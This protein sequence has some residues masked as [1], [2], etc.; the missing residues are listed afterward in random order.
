V[1]I[2]APIGRDGDIA[3]GILRESGLQA[4]AHANIPGLCA[5]IGKGAG[6]AVIAD[7]ALKTADLRPLTSFLAEQPAWSDFPIVV[8][9]KSGGG[10]ERNPAAARLAALLGNVTFLERP[11]HPTTMV[12]VVH[13][14]IR[15][16]KRQYEARASLVE[17][18]ESSDRLRLALT[19]G[20][21]GSWLYDIGQN[22]LQASHTCKTHFGQA[23][24]EPF[25][26]DDL[27][28]SI[29]PEDRGEMESAVKRSIETGS[30]H[31]IEVR[32]VWPAGGIH[33]IEMQG[34]ARQ[35]ADGA[36]VQLVGVSADITERK[37]AD[38]ERERLLHDLARER[39]ALARLTETLEQRVADE[40]IER[41]KVED[42]LR[43]GQKMEAIGQLTGGVAHDFNNLLMAVMG[44]LDLLQ[45]RIGDDP[46]SQRL[47]EGALQG[48]KRG[49]SLTQRMLAFARQQDLRTGSVD[50]K[51]LIHGMQDLLTRTLGPQFILALTL[52]EGLPSAEV[53][54]NQIELAVLNLVI[55]ARDAM[56]AGGTITVSCEYPDEV[57]ASLPE[58]NYVRIQ[59]TD[60]G[61]GMSS[62]VMARAVEPF[63]ST[64]AVGKGTGLGLSMVHGLAVQLGGLF[65]LSSVEGRGTTATIW[66]PVARAP[67]PALEES[68][69]HP[70]NPSRLATI[71]MVDDDPLIAMATAEMLKDL[72]HTVLEANSGRQALDILDSEQHIDLMMTDHAM[73]GMTGVELADAA[74]QKMPAL[75]ILLATGY[76]D[77]PSGRKSELPRLAKPYVQDTLKVAIDQLL[78]KKG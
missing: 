66:L 30:G 9:T 64:K 55:N 28:G 46:R 8:M 48:A 68:T 13:S 73:P 62:A 69:P 29:H 60:A 11:F 17:L 10:P 19:A 3:A 43:Q 78:S 32:S 21:L 41:R 54:S 61:I 27:R 2:L 31:R 18:T 25:G 16:R 63:F 14:A 70:V 38:I 49:A 35:D 75:P 37:T 4:E 74:R 51:A 34:R 12:S 67:A 39:S 6:V 71:L 7:E 5:Q 45:K 59:V 65:E 33:W 1:L 50:L 56:P 42:A 52:S 26:Y 36:V 76:A 23:P 72:G 53:D 22:L 15:G 57:P 77:L 44:N 24:D 20:H 47:I 58:G 40:L